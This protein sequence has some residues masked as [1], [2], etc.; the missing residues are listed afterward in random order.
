MTTG[1]YALLA[2]TASI[3][4]ASGCANTIRGV[5]QDAANTVNATPFWSTASAGVEFKL[6][7]TFKALPLKASQVAAAT[8]GDGLLHGSRAI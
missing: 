5:G 8:G 4:L 7:G 1:T 2:V 6:T 3:L